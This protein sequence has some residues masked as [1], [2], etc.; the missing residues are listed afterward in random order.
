MNTHID[1]HESCC[2]MV[3]AQ[4]DVFLSHPHHVQLQ[5]RYDVLVFAADVASFQIPNSGRPSLSRKKERRKR[6]SKGSSPRYMCNN[7][8]YMISLLSVGSRRKYGGQKQ[9]RI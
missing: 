8:E 9:I 4:S 1:S 6:R 2:G 5:S 3:E 7:I